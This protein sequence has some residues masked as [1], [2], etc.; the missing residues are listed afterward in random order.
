[1]VLAN[2]L[3]HGITIDGRVLTNSIESFVG[4][5][6][7]VGAD[8]AKDFGKP[9]VPRSLAGVV[10]NLVD[11]GFNVN[12][13]FW[14]REV[15]RYQVE[16]LMD[17]VRVT[18]DQSSE[19]YLVACEPAGWPVESVQGPVIAGGVGDDSIVDWESKKEACWDRGD[20]WIQ[21][22][23]IDGSSDFTEKYTIWATGVD[24]SIGDGLEISSGVKGVVD[25]S[26]LDI[27]VG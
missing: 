5:V 21:I 4:I 3:G 17:S 22:G 1:V 27:A 7:E 9:Y 8:L 26:A 19:S 2:R 12:D 15:W 11:T 18:V 24:G 13:C 16:W 20:R 23:E 14:G 6:E 10:L 25:D